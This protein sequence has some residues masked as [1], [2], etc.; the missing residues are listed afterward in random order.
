MGRLPSDRGAEGPRGCCARRRQRTQP[1]L[2]AGK[3]GANWR[4][5]S[6]TACARSVGSPSSQRNLGLL[7]QPSQG[8]CRHR[9]RQGL[10]QLGTSII[11]VIGPLARARAAL[12]GVAAAGDHRAVATRGLLAT[13]G[14]IG[15]RTGRRGIGVGHFDR[16]TSESADAASRAQDEIDKL[17]S[18][19]DEAA[20]SLF[21]ANK[22][23]DDYLRAKG[24]THP[25]VE[26][27]RSG[28]GQTHEGRHGRGTDGLRPSQGEGEEAQAR[29]E[30]AKK[31]AEESGGQTQ[32]LPSARSK[33]RSDCGEE[34]SRSSA[35]AQ[36]A[37][38]KLAEA[39]ANAAIIESPPSGGTVGSALYAGTE[40]R[41]QQRVKQSRG[42]IQSRSRGREGA[43]ESPLTTFASVRKTSSRKRPSAEGI[44]RAAATIRRS[45]RTTPSAAL[46]KPS[47]SRRRLRA[48][49]GRWP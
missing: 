29:A 38:A 17:N 34:S 25:R 9:Y 13:F 33:K 44:L 35:R 15:S 22:A 39:R 41:N 12:L 30:N 27:G 49:A 32:R 23:R 24:R 19:L 7:G 37:L 48:S 6:R 20:S 26:G 42:E 4:K 47:A 10:F 11:S 21:D 36:T 2:L 40:V 16:A 43:A 1:L 28:E 18:R 14:L 45:P 31:V 3:D 46:K 5:T 8:F